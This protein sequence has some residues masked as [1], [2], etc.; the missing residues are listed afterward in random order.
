MLPCAGANKNAADLR[1]TLKCLY[2]FLFG[3]YAMLVCVILAKCFEDELQ[4]AHSE[5]EFGVDNLELS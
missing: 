1:N 4:V 3:P 5:S 2:V